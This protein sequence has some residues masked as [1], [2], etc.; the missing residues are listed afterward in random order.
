MRK[1]LSL[2]A[3]GLSILTGFT[4]LAQDKKLTNEAIWAGGDFYAKSIY[5]VRSMNN[6]TEYSR[7]D[8]E[9]KDVF[10]NVYNYES[11]KKVR[12]ILSSQDIQWNNEPV[13]FDGYSFNSNE[14]MILLT[15]EKE[16]I[17]RHS[18]KSNYFIY[19]IASKKLS[20]LTDFEKGKQG[21]ASF[22]PD[23]KNVAFVRGNN[24]F[25]KAIGAETE[26]QITNDGE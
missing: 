5:G 2:L 19:E 4:A 9:G 14:K 10:I 3:L 1:A 21:L 13:F 17:Y 18:S 7:M 20:P 11:G 24:L 6:G 25:Y 26:T 16:K 15:T 22:S 8:R 23:G 12:T